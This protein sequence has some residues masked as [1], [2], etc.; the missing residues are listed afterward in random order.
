VSAAVTGPLVPVPESG[1]VHRGH[2]RVRLGDVTPTGR[3]RLDA[4]ARYLQDVSNDD[5]RDAALPDEW[6][7]V[8]RRTVID[9][10]AFPQL[11]E[12]LTLATFCGGIGGR[13]A[14][15]RVSIT[16]D[17]GGHIEAA[18]IWVH[19][20]PATARP[21]PLSD[22]FHRIFGPTAAGRRVSAKLTHGD[23]PPAA[24][25][26]ARP[27]PLRAVDFDMLG[28]VN[29]AASWAVVEEALGPRPEVA[30]PFRAEVEFRR[31]VEHGELVELVEWV[32]QDEHARPGA[33]DLWLI[34]PTGIATT[35]T[36]RP[37]PPHPRTDPD[38]TPPPRFSVA[39][40]DTTEA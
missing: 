7:W 9:V 31:A 17:G 10:H 2:R 5:T 1:R 4:T 3:L 26:G 32:E 29:N 23:P 27:W 37:P 21:R 22:D 28:H 14:E 16:G 40:S 33:I 35:A 38:P 13:W 24:L 39:N 25:I 36:I 34:G 6:A 8:V 15:R 18:T 30:P 19:V 11:D 12:E 20:D